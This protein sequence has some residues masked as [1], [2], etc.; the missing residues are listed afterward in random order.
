MH[1]GDEHSVGRQSGTNVGWVEATEVVDGQVRDLDVMPPDQ[2]LAG[3][4]DGRVL[5]HLSD[6][7]RSAGNRRSAG[8][9]SAADGQSVGLGA[10]GREDDLGRSCPDERCELGAGPGD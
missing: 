9:D 5:G 10:A 3:S 8:Q 2:L 6:D 1:D 4:Q 7:M